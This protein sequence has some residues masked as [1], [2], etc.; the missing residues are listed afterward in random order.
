MSTTI[1]ERVV[2]LQFDNSKFEKNVST[3]MSTLDKLKQSLRFDGASKGLNDI[4]SAAGK[5][6]MAG[7]GSAVETVSARFS[8]LQ[9]MGV[10]ALA[11]ITNSA[12]NAGKRIAKALT[13]DPITTGFKEYETQINATQTILANT[14]SKGTTIDDV[15]RALEELNRYADLTIYNFTEMTRNIGT[16]TAAGI[17]L[18][19]S[20]N[21]IQGIAN[22]AAV[23]GSTSQ[24]ASTAMYQLSQALAAGT[25]RLMDWNS[26]VNAGMGGEVFQ[27]A[28]KETS[29][30]LDT[31][32][33]AAIEATGSFRESLRTGWLTAEVLTETLKKFTTTGANEYVAEYT[34]LTLDAIEAETARIQTAT[35]TKAAI[36][37]VAESLAKASGK[38]KEEIASIL[39]FAQTATDAATKVK[40]FTQLWDVLKE[41]AQSGWAQTWKIIV[42]DFEEAKSL[43]TPL[44]DF[45]T[46]IINGISDWRNKIL[47]SALGKG[48][49]KLSEQIQS[50]V[51]PATKTMDV[52][53]ETVSTITDLGEIVD[54]VILGKFGNGQVRFDALAKAGYNYCEV[55]NKV[56]EKLNNGFRYTQEQIDAQNELLGIQKKSTEASEEQVEVV[57]DLSE[58]QKEEI[59]RLAK[60]SEAELSS[61]GYTKEQIS[62]FK[63]LSKTADKLGLSI[64]DFVDNLDQINGRW[65]LIESIKNA[66]KALLSVFNALKEA[67]QDI[68]PPKTIE[69][70]SEQ[71]FNIIAAI[72]KFSKSLL[73]SGKTA[74]KLKRTFKGVFA[75]LDI[76]RIVVGGPL[77]VA[78]DAIVHILGLF[79][80]NV[81]DVTAVIGDAIV[82]FRDWI[83]SALD[84]S[85]ILDPIVQGIAS[86]VTS[87]RSWVDSLKD[88]ENLPKDIAEGIA[89]GFGII[90]RTI[91]EFVKKIPEFLRN[92]PELISGMFNVDGALPEWMYYFEVAGQTIVELGKIILKK[93]NEFLNAHGFKEISEDAIQGLIN[94]F[95]EKAS[96]VWDAALEIG[97]QVL[98][99]I[100]EFLGIHSPSTEMEEVGK[101][102]VDGFVLG[103]QNGSSKLW[104][105]IQGIFG[106][107]VEYIRNLDFGAFVAALVGIGTVKAAGTAADALSGIATPFEGVG[108]VLE[109]TAVMLKKI[110]KPVKNVIKNFAKIE[111]A[112]AF[113][114]SMEGVKTLTL[115]LLMLVGAV[116]ILT[117]CDTDKLWNAVGVVA[118]LAAVLAALAFAMSKIGSASASFNLKD[119]L[120]I[121]GLTLG[122]IGI[123]AALVLV[124]ASVKMLGD[125][126][127]EQMKKGFLGLAGAVAAI[128]VLLAAFYLVS[129]GFVSL[130]MA[131][132]GKGFLG[133]AAAMLILAFVVKIA[134]KLEDGQMIQASKF[135]LG[136]VV[137]VGLLAVIGGL[138]GK[139]IDGMGKMMLS[140]SVSLLLMISVVKLAA[141]LSNEELKRGGIFLAG[142]VVFVGILSTIGALGGKAIKGVG[143]MMLSLSVSLLLMVAVVKLIGGLSPEEMLKGVA[144]ITVFT[145]IIALL[146]KSVMKN[147]DKAPKVAATI[148]AFSVAIAI[149]AAVAIVCGMISLPN[150]VKGVGA[151]TLL[152]AMMALMIHATKG[153]NNV[154]GNIVAIS[155]AIGLMVAAVALLTLIDPVKLAIATG[156][157]TVLMGMLTLVISVSGAAN[158]SAGVIAAMAVA[159]SAIGAVL[160]LL[161]GLPVKSVLASAAALSVL[162][163]VMTALLYALVPIGPMASQAL[164]GVLALTAMAVPL[165]AFVG[166]L[167]LMKNVSNAVTNVLALTVLASVMTL[168]LIPLSV[169]GALVAA[170]GGTILLGVVAL[171]AM[172]VPLLA[173]VGVL[174]VMS[175]VQNGIENALALAELMSVLGDVLF[176]IS[177]VA[178]LAVIGVNAISNMLGLITSLG[179]LVTAVGALM[180]KF[181]QLQEFIDSG[182][183]VLEQLAS[184]LGSII[185][186]FITGFTG[187][188]LTILPQLGVALSSFMVSILPFISIARTI[189][190]SVLSGIGILSAS[191]L[192]LTVAEFVN[193]LV[194]LGGIGLVNM[195]QQLS[196]FIVAAMPFITTAATI[197]PDM[198]SGVKS[199]AETILILTAA[200]LLNGLKLF[201]GS[202]LESFASQLP[203]LGAGLNGFAKSIDN[204]DSGSIELVNYAAQAIKTL[205]QASSE[206]PNAGGLLGQIV[207]ENDLGAFANQFPVLG[208]G[209]RGFLDS[210]GEFTDGQVSTVNC[211]AEAIKALAQASSEIPNS[212]GW[213]GQI[214]GE[215]DLGAFANQF[216]V[217]GLG[218]RGFLDNVGEFTDNQVQTVDS[219]AQAIKSLATAASEIPNTG[220]LLSQIVGDNDLGSFAEQFPSLGTGLRGFLNNV[221]SLDG[222]ATGTITSAASAVSSL[223][224]AASSIPNDGGWISKIIGDNSLATF[225]ENFPILGEGLA[226]FVANVGTFSDSQVSTVRTAVQAIEAVAELA[227]SDLG[228]ASSSMGSFGRKLTSFAKDLSEFCTNMPTLSTMN[229]TVSTIDKLLGAIENI[230]DANT[231]VL[232]TFADNLKKVSKNAVNKFVEAF[233]EEASKTNVK[234]AAT[235]LAGKAV[236]GANSKKESMKSAGK[237]LGDGLILG[238]NAKKSAVYWAAYALGQKAVEGEMDGQESESPSKATIRAGKWLGEGLIIGIADISRKVYNAGSNLGKTAT[239]TISDAVS[240][241]SDAINTDIDSQPTIRPV[242]DLSDVRSG[243]SSIGN[244]FNGSNSIGLQANVSAISS[245]MNSRSQNGTN[246]DVVY[247]IDKLNKKMDN[248]GNTTYSIAGITYDDG[249]NVAEAVKAI[250][251]AAIRERR[252]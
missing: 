20:V 187:E 178:P 34:G 195:G 177:I 175:G 71:I 192:A 226:G 115:S 208:R 75:I 6:N 61:L 149:L 2:S 158:K 101:N 156:A 83:K 12:V 151:V 128:G 220:G 4:N 99:S 40:T 117:L 245:M 126:D 202:S 70:R 62:A 170:T 78:F 243:I 251:R 135:L 108:E 246:A 241:I 10:T 16:F 55:Q 232:S 186:S 45:L 124:A 223:A 93:L 43:L 65:L 77:K 72:H 89:N 200:D 18:D 236:E 161:G 17:D 28:L 122:L 224:K 250:T 140:L 201:G 150:L 35:D 106:K 85:K 190:A 7:L 50:I 211:A 212:G 240:R 130:D 183:G 230:G 193:G 67:W 36:D 27:N 153:A 39:E 248:L 233:T 206:I 68:F 228:G 24:Q 197:T 76:I 162:M 49:T 181:P 148:L 176:K 171:L 247:A 91:R 14:S 239:G 51:K 111:K 103:I 87:F 58:V 81:L 252:V 173:F 123:G 5:V 210:V 244:M 133:I 157:M 98:E 138:G 100:K 30:A 73:V 9:V 185:G 168:L 60:L 41:A 64:D 152:S 116:A 141:G 120:N 136:F 46:N 26:V 160:Y 237:N 145:V 109:N 31:G 196:R 129:R 169:V 213:L 235:D 84:F 74:D 107:I 48:F 217:L 118:V 227:N 69:E 102:T 174:A 180:T 44:S 119:G 90:Y 80:L 205:A 56:N 139:A 38:S 229:L 19:T 47:E 33:E 54:E 112:I 182:I 144:A 166:V 188:V 104:E 96:A 215:N 204:F 143:G 231:G 88:S 57:S 127:P 249:S 13:I 25:I 113:N 134:G 146:V 37:E 214:V 167:A 147:G 79:N 154:V 42:G 234:T 121:Q 97:R 86:M 221:G 219:A 29:K 66:G 222:T 194:S 52:I 209:L 163:A 159:I 238:I 203:L 131:N 15:N 22:L 53:K 218:L 1:D 59:K 184:G 179:V 142:F 114:V 189:D 94:G 165:L 95:K 3:T 105:S 23:S 225:A 164:A 137:F 32:A 82:G 8:A 191:I 155:V 207:G 172:A 21:A 216:P 63:E 125:M 199:L 242:L 132:V 92:I 198:M 110:T 11:N